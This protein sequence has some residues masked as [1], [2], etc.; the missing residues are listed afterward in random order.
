MLLPF[1]GD[2]VDIII[3]QGDALGLELIA[4]SGRTYF[5]Y[6]PNLWIIYFTRQT[7][8]PICEGCFII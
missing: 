3:T 8:M 6:N 2:F 7:L 4:L 5:K 1:Q